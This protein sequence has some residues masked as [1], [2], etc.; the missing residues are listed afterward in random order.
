MQPAVAI[1]ANDHLRSYTASC[2]E[3]CDLSSTFVWIWY[4]LLVLSSLW[5]DFVHPPFY[6]GHLGKETW[7]CN[8]PCHCCD[9]KSVKS[10]NDTSFSICGRSAIPLSFWRYL[11]S[12]TWTALSPG[13]YITWCYQA[14]W[15]TDGQPSAAA[16]FMKPR[17]CFE[18]R[19][20]GY[21]RVCVKSQL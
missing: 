10:R 15:R 4:T 1:S 14:K 16:W 20:F 21:G 13:P 8:F 5:V 2:V 17:F 3:D 6:G 18:S 19:E 9:V 7:E 11:K 12:M